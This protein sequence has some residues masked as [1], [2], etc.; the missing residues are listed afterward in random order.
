MFKQLL[1]LTAAAAFSQGASAGYVRYDLSGPLNGYVIEHDDDQSVADFN[2]SA[3]FRGTLWSEPS[4]FP[5]DDEPGW[6]YETDY[7]FGFT[8]GRGSSESYLSG[9]TTHFANAIDGPANFYVYGFLNGFWSMGRADADVDFQRGADGAFTYTATYTALFS[10]YSTTFSGA[11]TLTG[12]ATRGAVDPQLAQAL[13]DAGGYA[14]DVYSTVPVYIGGG[15]P[16]PGDVPEPGSVALL[17][18]GAAG[19]AGAARVSRAVRRR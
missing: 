8:P 17:M 13:D 7:G 4:H 14:E 1:V 6:S 3:T 2:L 18:L 11:G 5:G 15:D 19:M 12:T 16:P 9:H 10:D